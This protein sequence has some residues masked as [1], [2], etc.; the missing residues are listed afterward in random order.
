MASNYKKVVATIVILIITAT[1]AVH[2]D[3]RTPIYMTPGNKTLCPSEQCYTLNEFI[4]DVTMFDINTTT[5]YFLP[6]RHVIDNEES[7]TLRFNNMPYFKVSG[8][9][10]KHDETPVIECRHKLFI[11][12]TKVYTQL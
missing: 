11:N 3:E 9:Y 5:I 10:S 1:S 8:I 12:F 2:G 7:G 4:T 6:G